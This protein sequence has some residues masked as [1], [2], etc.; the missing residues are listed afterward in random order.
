MTYISFY[1]IQ[2]YL[3]EESTVP[4]EEQEALRLAWRRVAHGMFSGKIS[5]DE[6]ENSIPSDVAFEE[7]V[8][9][10]PDARNE[11]LR[12]WQARMTKLADDA[13][14]PA[15]PPAVDIGDE[16]RKLVD[17]LLAK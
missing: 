15:D 9:E 3:L 12:K 7:A 8:E 16:A 1:G 6:F 10:S 11:V 2:D 4:A 14:A 13:G 5:R 17:R